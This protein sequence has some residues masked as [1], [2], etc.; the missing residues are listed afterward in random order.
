M[1]DLWCM[2]YSDQRLLPYLRRFEQQNVPVTAAELSS[3]AK[4]PISTVKRRLK[5]MARAGLIMRRLDS[6]GR[7]WGSYYSVLEVSSDD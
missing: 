6:P 1:M 4:M 2:K 3:A 7:R 5:E